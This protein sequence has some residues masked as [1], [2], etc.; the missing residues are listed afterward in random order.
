MIPDS[1]KNVKLLGEY[2]HHKRQQ[3]TSSVRHN[4]YN[5]SCVF[6]RFSLELF[7]TGERQQTSGQA[8]RLLGPH[9]EGE[10]QEGRG[11]GAVRPHRQHRP[12]NVVIR[13]LFVKPL[14]TLPAPTKSQ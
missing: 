13:R 3:L 11:Q 1:L 5:M 9:E 14:W 6:V 12:G 2:F 10:G 7:D 8:R 4:K